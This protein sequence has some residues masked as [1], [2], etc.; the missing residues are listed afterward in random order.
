MFANEK[1]MV[2]HGH[3]SKTYLPSFVASNA[4]AA[5][6]RQ[7]AYRRSWTDICRRHLAARSQQKRAL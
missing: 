7:F 5:G 6:I 3:V 4:L 2:A 1:G